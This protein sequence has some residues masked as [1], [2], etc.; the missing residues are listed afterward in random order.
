MHL[1]KEEIK[2]RNAIRDGLASSSIHEIGHFIVVG[3]SLDLR[4]IFEEHGMIDKW[5]VITE[6]EKQLEGFFVTEKFFI[7][8]SIPQC[9]TFRKHL[10][11]INHERESS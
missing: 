11:I 1:T 3:V 9:L 8:S 6:L 10:V 7:N 4:I 2:L 5:N